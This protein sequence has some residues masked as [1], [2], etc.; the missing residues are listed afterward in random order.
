MTSGLKTAGLCLAL[1]LGLAGPAQAQSNTSDNRELREFSAETLGPILKEMKIDYKVEDDGKGA[2]YL[3]FSYDGLKMSI[4]PAGCEKDTNKKCLGAFLTASW[5]PWQ[6]VSRS[7]MM[8]RVNAFDMKY[9]YVDAAIYEDNAPFMS[10][11]MIADHGMK[12]QN[13][14]VELEVF[15]SLANKFADAM[16][17]PYKPK[18]PAMLPVK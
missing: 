5:N 8:E 15:G 9:D 17:Q 2:P 3:T 1:S 7:E 11:Y 12:Y 18:E 13:I 10:R 6:G 16:D 4:Y 14:M